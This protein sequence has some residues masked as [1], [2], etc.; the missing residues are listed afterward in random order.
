ME[1]MSGCVV[2]L[3]LMLASAAAHANG[4][5]VTINASVLGSCRFTLPASSL[6]FVL[7]PL[8]AGTVSQTASVEYRCGKGTTG[9]TILRSASTSSATGGNLRRGAESLPYAISTSL[10]GN[11]NGKPK[12]LSVTVSINQANAANVTPGVYADS[13]AITLTP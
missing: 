8:A 13:I 3:I 7:D 10:S 2:A 1:A 12:T 9:S 4:H 6:S 11:G 5:A